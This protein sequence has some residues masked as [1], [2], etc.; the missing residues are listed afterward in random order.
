MGSVSWCSRLSIP[1]STSIPYGYQVKSWQLPV[2]APGT[3][4]ED[5][6]ELG[7]FGTHTGVQQKALSPG[8]SHRGHLGEEPGDGIDL[9]LFLSPT[10]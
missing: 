8:F 6:P 9:F 5:S 4:M 2:N 7:P 3:A 10:L 1:C